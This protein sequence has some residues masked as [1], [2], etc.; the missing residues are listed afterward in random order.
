M[1]IQTKASQVLERTSHYIKAGIIRDKPAWYDAVA[2]VPPTFNMEKLPKNL[3]PNQ[4]QDP[5]EQ[6][7]KEQGGYIKTRASAPE[8][9]QKNNFVSRVPKLQFLEDQLRDVFY[10]QHPWEFSRPKTLIEN[11]G[12]DQAKCDWSRML[13]LNKPLDG[14]SVVQR[15]LWLLQDSKQQQKEKT[16][17]EAYDQ[18]RFEFYQLRMAEEMNSVVSKEESLMF[19]AHFASSNLQWGVQ[20]EQETIDRWAKIGE[21]RTKIREASRS[22]ASASAGIA[23]TPEEPTNMWESFLSSEEPTNQ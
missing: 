2:A 6:L 8:R 12:D 4:L 1:K 21:K 14:E 16:L 9:A 23:A 20:K 18:A 15:T 17:F 22:K 13:Q 11:D 19:G 3:G 7:W 10:H 5:M